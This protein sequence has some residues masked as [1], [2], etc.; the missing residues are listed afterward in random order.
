MWTVTKELNSINVEIT[1]LPSKM[2][3]AAVEGADSLATAKKDA[4]ALEAKMCKAI[5]ELSATTSEAE[6]KSQEMT[7]NLSKFQAQY[8]DMA[9]D[10]SKWQDATK[11]ADYATEISQAT[12][13]MHIAGMSAKRLIHPGM[14]EN[15]KNKTYEA[16]QL[17]EV[18]PCGAYG[19]ALQLSCPI[20]RARCCGGCG[21]GGCH[22]ILGPLP[23]EGQQDRSGTDGGGHRGM[24]LLYCTCRML[25]VSE[26][27]HQ[28]VCRDSSCS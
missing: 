24:R 5:I 1:Q 9:K 7:D 2:A 28:L 6:K 11:M 14:V 17:H 12:T 20:C 27:D 8:T 13:T 16:S 18:V 4:L 15:C 3:Q 23:R 22:R 19:G 25:M 21:S 10:P 26:I